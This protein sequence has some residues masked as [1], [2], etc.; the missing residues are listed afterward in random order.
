MILTHDASPPL[1]GQRARPVKPG[2]RGHPHHAHVGG[3][4]SGLQVAEL[5]LRGPHA[6]LRVRLRGAL[7]RGAHG[8]GREVRQAGRKGGRKCREYMLWRAAE[9]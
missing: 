1:V 6:G 8:G 3:P 2:I 5:A 9:V 7:Q 4:E